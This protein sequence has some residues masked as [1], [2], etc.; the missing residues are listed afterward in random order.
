MTKP[1][2]VLER[3]KRLR[4]LREQTGLS[5]S[6]FAEQLDISEHTLKSFE[7]GARELSAQGA[8]EYSRMFLLMGIDVS[9]EFL[10]Y[11]KDLEHSEQKEAIINDE[12]HVHN[13]T[14]FFKKNNPLSIILKVQDSLMSPFFNKGD[15]VGGQKIINENQFPLLNGHICII[16]ATKG[17][18]FLRKIIKAD[19]RKVVCCT[20][21]T[22]GNNNPPLVEEIEAFSIAQATRHWRL[23]ALVRKL[24]VNERAEK[25]KNPSLEKS[26]NKKPLIKR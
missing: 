2:A 10:Y 25:A 18:Q 15:I 12:S 4:T 13:E 19:Q 24:Y 20:L 17:A 5:R 3:A 7:N 14:M 11:G 26:K 1:K 22:D 8:R 16:E 6:A 9:F 23:S 21:N